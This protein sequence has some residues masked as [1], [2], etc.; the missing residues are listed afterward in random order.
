MSIYK[1]IYIEPYSFLINDTS[2]SE[3]RLRF[4]KN[5]LKWK[6]NKLFYYWWSAPKTSALTSGKID[7]YKYFTDEEILHFNQKQIIE[8]TKF[9]YSHLG[10]G[11]AKA[12]ED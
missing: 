9:N 4:R 3:N 1:K 6:F 12:I 11:L 7:K 2:P 8:Q 5:L 10:K